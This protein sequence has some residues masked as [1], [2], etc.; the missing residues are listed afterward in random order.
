MG[1][2]DQIYESVL[3]GKAPQAKELVQ[4]AVADGVAI[5]DMISSMNRAMEEVGKRFSRNEIFLPEM[6][7][8]A[9]AMKFS[10]EILEPLIIGQSTETKGKFLIGTIKGDLHDIGKNLLITMFRGSGFQVV[11]IGVDVPKERF[12]EK[13]KE[14]SPQLVGISALL[15]TVLPQLQE[16][17]TFLKHSEVGKTCKIMVGGAAV[18]SA[19]ASRAG[20]DGY[21]DDVGEAVQVAKK[22]L[23]NG[24]GA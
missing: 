12:L 14:E 16:A 11:D 4:N 7:I 5:N 18:D 17:I 6:M 13:I 15:T 21:A 9:R 19:F 2:L 8:A 3:K 10:M 1:Y 20:A 23:A 24:N 22:L